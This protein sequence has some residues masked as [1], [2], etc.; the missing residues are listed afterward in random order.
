LLVLARASFARAALALAASAAVAVPL[1][2][3]N[4][5]MEEYGSNLLLV[6][7]GMLFLVAALQP[8]RSVLDARRAGRVAAVGVS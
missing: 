7:G 4:I 3:R 2:L 1:S 6:P 5:G 8:V